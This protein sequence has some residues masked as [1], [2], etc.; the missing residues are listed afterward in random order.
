[1]VVAMVVATGVAM[2]VAMVV[3]AGVA[4]KYLSPQRWI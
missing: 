4:I 2:M 1:M 3:A